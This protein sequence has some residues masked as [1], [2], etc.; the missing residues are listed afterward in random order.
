MK[1]KGFIFSIAKNLVLIVLASQLF[2]IQCMSK[3]KSDEKNAIPIKKIG[4]AYIY[5][6]NVLM[7]NGPSTKNKIIKNLKIASK[8]QIIKKMDIALKLNKINDYWYKIKAKKM[9][10]YVW[11]GLITPFGLKKDFNEDGK[12]DFLL[13]RNATLDHNLGRNMESSHIEM[14]LVQNQKISVIYKR[15]IHQLI[16]S[17][18]ITYEKIPGFSTKFLQIKYDFLGET[19][20]MSKNFYVIKRKK[21]YHSF[22]VK[23]LEGEGG[24]QC[25]RKIVYPNEKMGAKNKLKIIT[26]CADTTVCTCGFENKCF[27]NAKSEI[28]CK[29]KEST[30]I[31]NW[32]NNNFEIEK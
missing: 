3:T 6:E 21:I 29:V 5:G 25:K 9:T 27:N 17:I 23:L 10:G 11:G 2:L 7:R 12:K 15:K 22:E 31:Y 1:Q 4:S 26:K 30:Q 19:S 16:N 18:S 32:N 20:G 24:Y 8:V 14:R 13:I 28:P